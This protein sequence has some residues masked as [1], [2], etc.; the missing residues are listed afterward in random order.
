MNVRSQKKAGT[1]ANLYSI[2][3]DC[4]NC[5]ESVACDMYTEIGG[6]EPYVC[7]TCPT[8]K[9][10]VILEGKEIGQHARKSSSNKYLET[11]I[12]LRIKKAVEN[13]EAAKHSVKAKKRSDGRGTFKKRGRNPP[14]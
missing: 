1:R 8:C 13:N 9:E 12:A 2:F 5:Y 4:L 14:L 7:F 6:I 3:M 10:D 11:K